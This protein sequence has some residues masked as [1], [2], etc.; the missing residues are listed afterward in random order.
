MLGSMNGEKNYLAK[1]DSLAGRGEVCG[2]CV[3]GS[4]IE[5]SYQVNS[6]RIPKDTWGKIQVFLLHKAEKAKTQV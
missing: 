2:G 1:I 5:F 3:G 6:K 4:Y